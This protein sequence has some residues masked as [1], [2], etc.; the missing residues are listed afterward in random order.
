MDIYSNFVA[1][2]NSKLKIE[3]TGEKA[4]NDLYSGWE[5]NKISSDFNEIYYKSELLRT[6]EEL[7]K[8]GTK[9]SDVW[10]LNKSIDIKKKYVNYRTG[11]LNLSNSNSIKN[12]YFLGSPT[13]LY[14]NKIIMLL[15]LAFDAFRSV[16][17]ICNKHHI[18]IPS[19]GLNLTRIWI[20]LN[21]NKIAS[22]TDY[23]K[24]IVF[25]IN[26]IKDLK[27]TD[28]LNS[29]IKQS[30]RGI[31]VDFKK[32]LNE[33]F[34]DNISFPKKIE[35]YNNFDSIFN[36]YERPVIVVKNNSPMN[37]ESTELSILCFDFL[38]SEKFKKN[39]PRF[40]ETNLISQ[41]S[42]LIYGVTL[43][44]TIVP[45]LISI[46]KKRKKLIEIKKEGYENNH[47]NYAKIA[48]LNDELNSLE[49]ELTSLEL[50]QKNIE[51]QFS[52]HKRNNGIVESDTL[53]NSAAMSFIHTNKETNA[54][55]GEE[56]LRENKLTLVSHKKTDLD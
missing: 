6:I 26:D 49:N 32:I 17:S 50:E 16:Y 18:V 21:E 28:T 10:I 19:R 24:E 33:S 52:Q 47:T 53:N 8:S 4:N 43:A 35:K 42:P 25:E 23:F 27:L 56:W 7:I 51:T 29:E 34:K 44:I 11:T 38:V 13:P 2:V 14:T 30:L 55:K 3:L 22:L 41:N 9:P 46:L 45:S 36:S 5:I 31:D 1:E 20:E 40:L 37:P 54:T 48:T 39:N 15:S 12:L